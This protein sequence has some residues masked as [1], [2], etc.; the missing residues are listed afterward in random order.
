M[1]VQRLTAGMHKYQQVQPNLMCYNMR[2]KEIYQALD[3]SRLTL[4]HDY[5]TG[6]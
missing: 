4:E 6:P 2:N 1:K 5:M 3:S